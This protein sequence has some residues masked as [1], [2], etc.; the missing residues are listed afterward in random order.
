M[1]IKNAKEQSFFSRL[2][3]LLLLV[4]FAILPSV[5]NIGCL[6]DTITEK[7]FVYFGII[8]MLIRQQ[9]RGNR[10]NYSFDSY[11]FAVQS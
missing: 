11:I 5:L 3:L 2:S 6:H 1:V 9:K 7:T 4:L 8:A 10:H